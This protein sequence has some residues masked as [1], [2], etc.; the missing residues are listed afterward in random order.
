M[1]GV[2]IPVIGGC[3]AGWGGGGRGARI[4]R[5]GV[6]KGRHVRMHIWGLMVL[7][8]LSGIFYCGLIYMYT[9]S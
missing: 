6:D 8:D 3:V 7:S 9:S 4:R 2:R 1:W 5:R